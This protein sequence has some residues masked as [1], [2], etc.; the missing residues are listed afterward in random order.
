MRTRNFFVV[1]LVAVTIMLG[2]FSPSITVQESATPAKIA[3]LTELDVSHSLL[4]K[5]ST[6]E[7]KFT[8]FT[9]AEARKLK[10]RKHTKKRRKAVRKAHRRANYRHHR[11]SRAYRRGYGGGYND[12]GNN[13]GAVIGAAVVGAVVGAA[14]NEANQN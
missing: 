3:S 9:Q 8:L 5:F 6:S 7:V 1:K 10:R 4:A 2:F 11:K 12:R 14:V 13:T